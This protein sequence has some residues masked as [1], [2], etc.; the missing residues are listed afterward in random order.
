METTMKSRNVAVLA[1]VVLTGLGCSSSA[2]K[3]TC[4]AAGSKTCPKDRPTTQ[5]DVDGCNREVA[6]CGPQLNAAFAC[7]PGMFT[8]VCTS[9]GLSMGPPLAVPSSCESVAMAA[10]ECVKAWLQKSESDGG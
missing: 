8:S 5:E 10:Q 1:A 6:A 4:P 3:Y 2:A 7:D 9:D